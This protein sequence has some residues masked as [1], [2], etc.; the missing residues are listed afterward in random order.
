MPSPTDRRAPAPRPDALDAPLLV[1]AWL[2]PV[3]PLLPVLEAT[4]D[5]PLGQL[6]MT[7]LLSWAAVLGYV[8]LS[9]TVGEVLALNVLRVAVR[10]R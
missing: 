7:E 1:R 2:R 5:K 8:T 9:V 3:A 6:T 10:G 4:R